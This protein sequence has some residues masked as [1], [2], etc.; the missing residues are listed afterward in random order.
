[1]TAF[2]Y[3]VTEYDVVSHLPL[4]AGAHNFT[5]YKNI[6]EISVRVSLE[7]L[8]S[9]REKSGGSWQISFHENVGTLVKVKRKL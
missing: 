3:E 8:I 5:H 9:I 7:N 2:R 6:Y 1:M 4:I